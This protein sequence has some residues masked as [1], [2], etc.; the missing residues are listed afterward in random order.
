MLVVPLGVAAMSVGV[1]ACGGED[2]SSTSAADK[3]TVV[4]TTLGE[5][6]LTYFVKP[7]RTTVE[8]GAV[9]FSVTNVG[10]LT[11]EFVVYSN[12]DGVATGDLPID[13]EADAADLVD[14]N[15]VG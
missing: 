9:T 10:E 3:G 11:H 5:S 8:A 6:G 12:A 4:S 7:D 2:D 15:I 14:A 1:A 13:A